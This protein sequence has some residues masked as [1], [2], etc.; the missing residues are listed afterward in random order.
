MGY[1]PKIV[2]GLPADRRS[3][4]LKRSIW[5]G[6]ASFRP[7]LG[8]DSLHHNDGSCGSW[9]LHPEWKCIHPSTR[10]VARNS[11]P[12]QSC[13]TVFLRNW[14]VERIL[15]EAVSAPAWSDMG[16]YA[17]PSTFC[18]WEHGKRPFL[19]RYDVY[20]CENFPAHASA[21]HPPLL[22]YER[23]AGDHQR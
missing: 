11:A 16:A 18:G 2:I 21:P 4:L 23:Y 9:R 14:A 20:L 8:M 17:Q 15:E 1:D 10:R 12:L 3:L 19:R 5:N 13:S 22:A 6:T 7:R